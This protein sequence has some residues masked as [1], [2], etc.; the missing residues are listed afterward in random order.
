MSKF[1][2]CWITFLLLMVSGALS[3][4]VRYKFDNTADFSKAKTYKWITLKS[5]APIDELTD[6]Q[7][8]ASLDA[9][10]ARKGF[11]KVEGDSTA[12]LFIAYQT[13]E[14]IDEQFA[15]FAPGWSA[16]PGWNPAAGTVPLVENHRCSM[17]GSWR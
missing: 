16:G 5:E 4:D 1:P 13:T 2:I 3:Q 8:K 11:K 7:I 10:L 14:H 9:A 15:G 6:E 12:D 17:Q